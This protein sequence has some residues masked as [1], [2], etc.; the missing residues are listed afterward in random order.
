MAVLNTALRRLM[1]ARSVAIVG[2][3]ERPDAPSGFVL[4]NLMRCGFS[5]AIWPVHPSA[6]S[7][8]GRSAVPQLS[9]LAHAPDAV[10]I[11]I[12]AAAAVTVVRQAAAMGIPGAVVLAS[13]FA[14]LGATGRLL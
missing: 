8:F 11:A 10:V 12:P 6:K 5:G 1:E 13:G 4:R 7:I 3:S 9:D 14:E 2:A